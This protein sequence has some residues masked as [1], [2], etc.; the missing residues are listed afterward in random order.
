MRVTN[1]ITLVFIFYLIVVRPPSLISGGFTFLTPT[2]AA[3]HDY[4]I[5]NTLGFLPIIHLNSTI[6]IANYHHSVNFI[7]QHEISFPTLYIK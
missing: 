2:A 5:H 1:I 4:E 3:L 7:L 6:P